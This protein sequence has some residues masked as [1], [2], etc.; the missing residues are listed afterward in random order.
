MSL[1]TARITVDMIVT[2]KVGEL[3]TDE[4]M[5]A[6]IANGIHGDGNL[7]V[8]AIAVQSADASN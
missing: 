6:I 2:T 5:R 1:E 8:L 4:E 3:P 7:M